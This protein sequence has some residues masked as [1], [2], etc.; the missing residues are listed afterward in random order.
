VRKERTSDH[1]RSQRHAPCLPRPSS[2]LPERRRG[3]IR[4]TPIDRRS[5]P[6]GKSATSEGAPAYCQVSP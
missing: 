6:M 2:C 1:A 4:N 3:F 5:H